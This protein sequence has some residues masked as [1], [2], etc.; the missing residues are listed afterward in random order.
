[1]RP[2]SDLHGTLEGRPVIVMGQSYSLNYMD[3]EKLAPFK[4]ISCNRCL[5]PDSHV[6]THPDYYVCVDRD[7]YAQ[8]VERIK[9][10]KGTRV[11]SE[12]LFDPNNMHK[13]K[14][15]RTHW[16]PLQ[17]Y[18]D[19][20]WFGFRPVSTSR[21]RYNGRQ[22]RTS[23]PDHDRTLRNGILHAFGMDLD[24]LIAGA[25]NVAFSMFQI[26]AAMGASVIGICGVDLAWES[27]KKSHSFGDGNGKSKG[28]FA[29][30]PRHT[31]P[32]FKSGA[33]ECRRAGIE[34]YNLSPRGVLSPTI[35]A[36]SEVDFHNRFAKYADGDMLY[37]RKLQQSSSVQSKGAGAK[38][39]RHNRYKPSPPNDGTGL[40]TPRGSH[41]TGRREGQAGLRKER[42]A[43][44]ARSR[45]KG[46][47]K[48][49]G[50]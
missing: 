50:A 33:L 36:L 19:F 42:A 43:R 24:L 5:R 32:F 13:K 27:G 49:E 25:A 40:S 7:P 45:R 17:P 4:T 41:R 11:L 31:L 20:E 21:P 8:E 6:K 34:V 29:L 38:R 48:T 46:P 3:L 18:P 12:M 16:A 2:A 39:L 22:V 37:P 10:F 47:A 28:A 35:E 44:L 23:W 26:A 14:A 15:I 30:N 9:D 1:M